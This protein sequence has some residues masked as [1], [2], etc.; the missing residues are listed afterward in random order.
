MRIGDY[1]KDKPL[2]RGHCCGKK[3][4][5]W[6]RFT[7]PFQ[8]SALGIAE[9]KNARLLG[10]VGVTPKLKRIDPVAQFHRQAP[11]R[12]PDACESEHVFQRLPLGL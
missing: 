1:S 3:V 2:A 10:S 8:A 6:R 11:E 7:A 12:T 5:L 9:A 4:D